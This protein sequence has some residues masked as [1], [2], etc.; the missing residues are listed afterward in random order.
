LYNVCDFY[1]MVEDYNK[2]HPEEVEE[3]VLKVIRM[4]D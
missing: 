4:M 1:S 2:Q 3:M